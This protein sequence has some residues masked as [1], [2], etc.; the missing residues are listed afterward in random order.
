MSTELY[1]KKYCTSCLTEYTIQ[2]MVICT[3]CQSS[4]SSTFLVDDRFSDLKQFKANRV[5]REFSKLNKE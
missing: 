1:E 5:L 2:G 3:K 4:K